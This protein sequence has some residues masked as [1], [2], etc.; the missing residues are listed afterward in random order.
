MSIDFA[1]I[2]AAFLLGLLSAPHCAA[3]CGGISGAL[4]MAGR[5]NLLHPSGQSVIASS[6]PYPL[7]TDALIYGSGKIMGYMALGAFA[8]AG[9][10][11]L[12]SIHNTGFTVLHVLSGLLMIALGLY[13]AGWWLAVSQFERFAYRLWQPVL[14]RLHGLSLAHPGNKLLAGMAWGLLPCGIVYSV[15]GLALASGST[16]AGLLLM[17][18]FGVG[19]LPFVLLSGG[20]MQSALPLLKRPW[21]RQI[22]GLAM[23]TLGILTLVKALG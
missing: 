1:S 19:T 15:L 23:M 14:K 8:G 2:S 21:L 12:G 10:F 18:A 17:L 9:G 22:S 5:S 3:M 6:S 20:L 13:I 7:A 11:L 4:L 16:A